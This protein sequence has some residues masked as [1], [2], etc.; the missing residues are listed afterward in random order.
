MKSF[1]IEIPQTD[2][3]DLRA[4]LAGTRWPDEVPGTGWSR[5]VPLGHLRELAAYWAGDFDW[6]AQE[7]ALN[8]LP[9]LVTDVDGQAIHLIHVRSPEPGATPLLVTHGWPSSPVEFLKVIGPLSDPRAHGG[10]PA[11]AFHLVIPSLPGYGFSTPL[12]GEG[13]GNLFRVA[14][15]WAEVMSRLGYE[16]YAVY[17]TDAGAGVAGM[18]P[19]VAPGRVTGVY[20]T[21]TSAAMP[22]GPPIDLNGLSGV[23]CERAERFNRFQLDGMGYLHLQATRPQTLAYALTDSPVAQLAWIVEKVHEW[24][25]PA[26]PVDRDQLLTNVSVNWFQR[27]GA[28][29]AHAT[30]EGIQAWRAMAAH[31]GSAGGEAPPGPP[32]GVAVFAADNTVRRLMDPAG[33]F[34]HWSEYDRGGHFPAMEVPDLLVDDVRAFVRVLR[35]S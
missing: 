17:G 24:T 21:G 19:M 31:G 14:G 26:T 2:I 18:L 15:A 8:E 7:A 28:S 12:A 25:D 35:S 33:A 29:S 5:G 10:D 27:A 22:F 23:D 34:A 13:W 16:R 11:D 32:M 3:D 1:R 20:L 9:N 4:R 30:Y 6:R